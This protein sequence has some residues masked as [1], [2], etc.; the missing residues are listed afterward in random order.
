MKTGGKIIIGVL[1]AAAITIGGIAIYNKYFRKKSS[2]DEAE[3]G[4]LVDE[5]IETVGKITGTGLQTCTGASG[6][7]KRQYSKDAIKQMQEWLLKYGNATVRGKINA[8]GGADGY[9]GSG[10]TAAVKAARAQRIITGMDN[11]RFL[12]KNN[13]KPSGTTASPIDEYISQS[14]YDALVGKCIVP[15]SSTVNVR[16]SPVVDDGIFSNRLYQMK[17]GDSPL[18][19]EKVVNSTDNTDLKKWYYLG[20]H[21]SGFK[22]YVRED[23]VK[24]KNC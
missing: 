4:T 22:M 9:C 16:K 17:S 10:F 23:A 12:A 21:S 3:E 14:D 1:S 7:S 6:D 24:V 18:K 2:E 19:I 13:L 20:N 5:V 15:K 8:A 11:L